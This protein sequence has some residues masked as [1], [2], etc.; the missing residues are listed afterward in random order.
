MQFK[1]CILH[2]IF[3]EF[4]KNLFNKKNYKQN[5]SLLV[6]SPQSHFPPLPEIQFGAYCPIQI[7]VNITCFKFYIKYYTGDS[8][9][10]FFAQ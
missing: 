9:T 10:L 6:I 3:S 1:K 4:F 5:W 2:L 7:F 8:I